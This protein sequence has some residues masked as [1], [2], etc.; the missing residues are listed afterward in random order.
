MLHKA[1]AASQFSCRYS[2][3]HVY[4]I[5]IQVLE[6]GNSLSR[7][8]IVLFVVQ[9]LS[10]DFPQASKTSVG[11]VVQLL[12]RASCFN[13]REVFVVSEY[14]GYIF[15]PIQVEKRDDDSSLMQLKEEVSVCCI[16]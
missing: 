5:P 12:Y 2:L 10:N 1:T 13:V 7:K 11:H 6:S 3:R 16:G 9:R 8:N 14:H 15:L 4:V